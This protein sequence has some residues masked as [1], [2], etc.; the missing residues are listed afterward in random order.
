[1][2]NVKYGDHYWAVFLAVT[3]VLDD[4]LQERAEQQ[5]LEA[6]YADLDQVLS[7][8]NCQQG[9]REGLARS[10]A[11]LSAGRDYAVLLLRFG[12]RE[13]AEAFVDAYAPPVVGTVEVTWSCAG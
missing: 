12:T 6:G 5:A 2:L 1:M 4:P 10:G 3:G 9:A 8:V 7:S 11:R 13:E